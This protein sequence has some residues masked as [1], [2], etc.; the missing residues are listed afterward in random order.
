MALGFG[1]R[2]A[3]SLCRWLDSRLASA[4]EAEEVAA[5]TL[6]SVR[7]L[8]RTRAWHADVHDRLVAY[9]SAL[10]DGDTPSAAGANLTTLVSEAAT[11]AE[12]QLA[13]V[14]LRSESGTRERP[15]LFGHLSAHASVT[16]DL[17]AIALFLEGLEVGPELIAIRELAI[18]QPEVGIQS[19][20]RESLRAEVELEALYRP[21]PRR[22]RE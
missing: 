10:V 19:T 6:E 12:V 15:D 9:D 14:Q 20:R 16:G 5:R 13:S 22:S 3:P 21:A 11:G 7:G 2:A 4:R 1:A 8:P 17:E 18:T